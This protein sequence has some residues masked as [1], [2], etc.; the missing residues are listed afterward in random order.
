MIVGSVKP[1][2][3]YKGKVIVPRPGKNRIRT[4][5]LDKDNRK[6]II[7]IKKWWE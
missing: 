7:P 4:Q 1:K 3:E 6:R 5:I 2:K